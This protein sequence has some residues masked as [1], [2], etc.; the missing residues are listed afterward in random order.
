[1][2]LPL[3]VALL[4]LW[5][6]AMYR[7]GRSVLFPP[8][9]L[10]IV[11]TITLFAVW[12]CGDRYFPL[13]NVANEIVLA[14]VL[15]FS[16]GGLCA[17]VAPLRVQGTLAEVGARRRMQV[18]RWLTVAGILFLLNIPLSYLYYKELSETIAP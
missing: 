18:D 3:T 14:G 5:S 10:G 11:W 17:A 12:L 13:T 7:Y 8:A 4:A 2:T 15:A 9:S 16:V 6:V 1:M